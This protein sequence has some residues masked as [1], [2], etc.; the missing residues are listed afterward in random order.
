MAVGVTMADVKTLFLVGDRF[1]PFATLP[2]VRTVSQFVADV[3]GGVHQPGEHLVLAE[4][5]GLTAFQWDRVRFELDR[6]GL[7]ESTRIVESDRGP[8]CGQAET[9]K[10]REH[11]VLIAGLERLGDTRYRA[12][13]RLH[14]D[15]ELLLDHQASHVQGMVVLEAARQMFLAVG[16]R[17]YADGAHYAYTLGSM[18]SSFQA[19]LYPLDTEITCEV[20]TADVSDPEQLDFDV[21]IDFE[22]AG[23]PVASVRMRCSAFRSAVLAHKE[24]RGAERATRYL[25]RRLPQLAA[26]E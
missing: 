23:L 3:R 13:L 12:A 19:F 20:L 5:Q 2:S 7:A 8:L 16:E 10:H 1:A 24:H 21:R 4:G 11:N 6:A 17:F 25:L 18:E 15:Q 26:A 9:H 14:G 22:Q